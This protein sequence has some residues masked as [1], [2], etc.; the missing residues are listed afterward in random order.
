MCNRENDKQI[1]A[2]KLIGVVFDLKVLVNFTLNK[3]NKKT[4]KI[5]IADKIKKNV[6][7]LT[8]TTAGFI[9]TRWV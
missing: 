7:R 4:K 1:G 9:C 2:I 8:T 5:Y 6:D 3:L